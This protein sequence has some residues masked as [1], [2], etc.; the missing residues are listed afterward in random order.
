MRL[1]FHSRNFSCTETRRVPCIWA[2]TSVHG[3]S[4][5]STNASRG[6]AR[7]LAEL[8]S[9]S[10]RPPWRLRLPRILDCAMASIRAY[11]AGWRQAPVAGENVDIAMLTVLSLIREA[12]TAQVEAVATDVRVLPIAGDGDLPA[13]V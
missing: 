1:A 8:L 6:A 2:I 4:L 12:L 7:S 5:P 10:M 3:T 9:G 11:R 13:D